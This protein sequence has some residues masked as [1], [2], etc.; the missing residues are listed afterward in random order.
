MLFRGVHIT[1]TTHTVGGQD[2]GDD[3]GDVHLR[4]IGE[5]VFGIGHSVEGG[6][7][8]PV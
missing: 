2:V 3:I 7:D 1:A 6:E 4:R 5:G 8:I